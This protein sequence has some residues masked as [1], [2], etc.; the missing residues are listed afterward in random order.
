[1][2]G[3]SGSLQW[4]FDHLKFDPADNRTAPYSNQIPPRTSPSSHH[5]PTVFFNFRDAL[6]KKSFQL[7]ISL[8]AG[9]MTRELYI[10]K[11]C[12]AFLRSSD[13][14]LVVPATET[15]QAGWPMSTNWKNT[16]YNSIFLIV[17]LHNQPVQ[18][19]IDTSRLSRLNC[20]RL[21][22][23]PHFYVLVPAVLLSGSATVI[24]F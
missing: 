3:A 24:H 5:T 7:S 10:T 15:T 2:Q 12:P 16:S 8:M 14:I 20:Q 23:S 1:M 19:R 22:L 17:G 6:Q 13:K 18:I 21:R 9:G 4:Q 11:G